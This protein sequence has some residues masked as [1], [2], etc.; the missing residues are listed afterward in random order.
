MFKTYIEEFRKI[1]TPLRV[2]FLKKILYGI[3]FMVVFSVLSFFIGNGFLEKLKFFS[4]GLVALII[5]EA[6]VLVEVITVVRNG[7]S[8]LTGEC[9]QSEYVS[10][11]GRVV[12]KSSTRKITISNDGYAYV[13]YDNKN[14]IKVGNIVSVYLP[15]NTELPEKEG[16]Y[17]ILQKYLVVVENAL[18]D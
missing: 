8:K 18:P 5:Y 3:L 17:E 13:I 16:A 12:E 11:I 2:L 6:F 7:Y 4:V 9:V 15:A 14:K 1:E 10:F